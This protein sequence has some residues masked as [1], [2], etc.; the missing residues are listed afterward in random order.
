MK[1]SPSLFLL[2]AVGLFAAAPLQAQAL[3]SMRIGITRE[4]SATGGSPRAAFR[5]AQAESRRHQ[6]WPFVLGGAVVGAT[7]AGLVLANGIRQTDD[8][9]V[10]P[11]YVAAFIGVGAG[12][13]AL[14]GW[15]VSAV[16]R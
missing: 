15:A 10:F 8:A 2:G 7:A 11:Q 5:V 9:M 16:I 14:G 3:A 1:R 6:R 4:A 12:I 13:G